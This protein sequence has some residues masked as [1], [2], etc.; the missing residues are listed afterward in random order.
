MVEIATGGAGQLRGS[1]NGEAR[2]GGIR[3]KSG[4]RKAET[5]ADDAGEVR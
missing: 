2:R 1:Q 3:K 5:P 4:T